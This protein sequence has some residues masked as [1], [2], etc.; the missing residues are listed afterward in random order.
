MTV[1][2]GPWGS[3]LATTT[4]TGDAESQSQPSSESWLEATIMPSTR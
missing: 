3:A 2:D 1:T 4:G